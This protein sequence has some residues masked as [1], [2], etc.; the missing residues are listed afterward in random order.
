MSTNGEREVPREALR[1]VHHHPGRLRLRAQAFEG[2]APAFARVRER[3]ESIAGITRLD[4]NART[5][6]LLVSYAPATIEPDAIID[7]VAHAADLDRP[8]DEPRDPNR[9]AQATIDTARE[10][11]AAVEELTGRRT[12]LR[13][14]IPAAMLGFAAYSW[15]KR[16]GTR[17]PSWENL[18]YWSYQLFVGLHRHE[19][20]ATAGAGETVGEDGVP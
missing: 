8:R 16:P 17:I 19:I 13:T 5:G 3:L 11:N 9:P 2:A 12:D 4:H 10:L 14:L 15:V 1:L 6:S 18:A 7:E 20:D